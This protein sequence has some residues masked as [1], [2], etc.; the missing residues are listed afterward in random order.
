MV[1]LI[2]VSPAMDKPPVKGNNHIYNL[3][4]ARSLRIMLKPPVRD[5][6]AII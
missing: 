1:S 6:D 3:T 4:R 2:V 5:I